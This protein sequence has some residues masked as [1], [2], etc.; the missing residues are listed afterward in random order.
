MDDLEYKALRT[1]WILKK[2]SRRKTKKGCRLWK[3]SF[4]KKGYGQIRGWDNKTHR[5]HRLIYE[6]YY[7]PFNKSLFVLH[8]CDNPPCVNPEHLFL[9]DAWANMLDMVEKGRSKKGK[10]YKKKRRN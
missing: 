2:I 9:G 10:K 6:I 1:F 8:K 5:A 3:G 7:G 4:D